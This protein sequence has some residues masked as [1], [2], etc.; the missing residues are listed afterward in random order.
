MQKGTLTVRVNA[1]KNEATDIASF[2]LT[3]LDGSDLPPFSAGAHI[4]VHLAPGLVRQYSLCNSP[5]ERHRYVIGVL[6]APDSRGGSVLLHNGIRNGSR[7]SISMPRNNFALVPAAKR[8]VLFAG[9]IGITPILSM[10]EHLWREDSPFEMHYCARSRERLA[11]SAHI[12]A[13]PY[14][15][16]VLFHFDNGIPAQMLDPPETLKHPDAETHIYVCGP[17]G[18]IANIAAAARSAGWSETQIHFEHFAA[19]VPQGSATRFTVTLAQSGTTIFVE[20]NETVVQALARCGI[21]IPVACQQGL[22]G[23]CMTRIL[24]GVPDHR[25]QLL[26]PTERALNEYFLPCCSK[27]LSPEMVL[28]LSI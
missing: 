27:A 2:E 25:D 1:K 8:S 28:D 21:D 23:T 17:A 4:D 19:Q 11:F 18:F 24:A 15:D 14:A 26:T 7:L 20:P 6:R 5:S 16:R 3:S 12:S 13:S 9:G 10:A 22:C